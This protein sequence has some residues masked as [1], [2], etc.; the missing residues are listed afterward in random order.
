MTY[1]VISGTDIVETYDDREEAESVERELRVEGE[2]PYTWVAETIEW[3]CDECDDEFTTIPTRHD[4]E[5][6]EC[7]EAFVD[8]EKEYI[9]R[10][11]EA[12][13]KDPKR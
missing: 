7:G 6:C 12:V 13:P 10:S 5:T 8:H 4:P 1:A 9:R 11:F 3:F 2:A